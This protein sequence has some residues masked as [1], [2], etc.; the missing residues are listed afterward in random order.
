MLDST[1]LSFFYFSVAIKE[2]SNTSS[3]R[4]QLSL[5]FIKGK[6][7]WWIELAHL[8]VDYCWFV[9]SKLLWLTMM[10]DTSRFGAAALIQLNLTSDTMLCLED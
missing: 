4:I 8:L 5:M 3:Q 1:L 6:K 9:D 2:T 7:V 10:I